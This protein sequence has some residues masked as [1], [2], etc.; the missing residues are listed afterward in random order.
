M[1]LVF[2]IATKQRPLYWPL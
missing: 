2:L 1:Q